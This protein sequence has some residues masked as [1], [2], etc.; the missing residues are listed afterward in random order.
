MEITTERLKELHKLQM[1]YIPQTFERQT[2]V[3][4]EINNLMPPHVEGYVKAKRTL[5]KLKKRS[6]KKKDVHLWRTTTQQYKMRRALPR[7]FK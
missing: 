1:V 6:H 4:K 2:A 7:G 3:R 5:T